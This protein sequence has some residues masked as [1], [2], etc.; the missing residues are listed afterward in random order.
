MSVGK[1]LVGILAGAATGAVLG[2][3][4]APAKGSDLR[5]R[6]YKKG[7]K[8]TDAVKESFN[9]FLDTVSTKFDKLKD[10]VSEFE[11]KVKLH[12]KENSAEK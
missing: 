12:P 4:F 7:E 8:G 5:K 10:D 6:I 9:E 11:D 2:I 1:V 3:L